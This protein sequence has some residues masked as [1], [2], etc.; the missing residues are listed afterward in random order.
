VLACAEDIAAP[1]KCPE[2]CPGTTIDIVDTIL[3]SAIVRDSAYGRP[4]GYVPA[5]RS[6]VMLAADLP[7]L[8]L[9]SRA[10]FQTNAVQTRRVIQS[11]DTV[12]G[13][14][15]ADSVFLIVRLLRRD[16]TATNLRLQFYHLR[17]GLDSTTTL[18][19]LADSFNA[20]PFRTLRVDS[21]LAKP[22]A[23]DSTFSR[24]LRLD[25]TT[26]DRAG[27]D[28]VFGRVAYTIILKLDTLQLPFSAAD[29][30]KTAIGVR[31]TAD[32]QASIALGASELGLGPS[33]TWFTRFD[34]LGTNIRVRLP[35]A[36][37]AGAGAGGPFDSFVFTPPPAPLDSNLAVGGV[38]SARSLLRVD[39]PRHIRD[40][41][42]I[43]R[44]TLILVPARPARGVPADSFFV[45][46][47]QASTD[48]GA[49]TPVFQ[50]TSVHPDSTLVR[51]G[52]TDT[53]RIEVTNFLRLWQADTTVPRAIV[54]KQAPVTPGVSGQSLFSEAATFAEIRFYS[55]RAAAFRPALHITYVPRFKFGVP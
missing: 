48:L 40:S 34:S 6:G 44:A 30:G 37:T 22:A 46:A 10:I 36:G 33:L 50:S 1:G 27:V 14:L 53:V 17:L 41:S 12:T 9:D 47:F 26:R 23:F 54:L 15:R 49:K 21:L 24:P 11:S 38:P 52:A 5:H 18:A 25:S 35:P 8:T 45:H 51:I 7:G 16:T 55:S 19:Q 28:T 2:F 32:S 29:S 13:P 4:I 31:V 3:R 42:Q 20:A 39:L 43:V